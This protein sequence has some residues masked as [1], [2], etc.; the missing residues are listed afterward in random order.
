MEFKTMVLSG[1]RP[2][3]YKDLLKPVL[4]LNAIHESYKTRKKVDI[5]AE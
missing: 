4:I 2:H 1:E 3:A 5:P